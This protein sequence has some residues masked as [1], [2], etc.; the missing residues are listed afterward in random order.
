MA[1]SSLQSDIEA[2][3]VDGI[4]TIIADNVTTNGLSNRAYTM[5]D[6]IGDLP[7]VIV[8]SEGGKEELYNYTIS[9]SV[10]SEPTDEGDSNNF[11][12]NTK[13]SERVKAVRNVIMYNDLMDDLNSASS[14]T[15][16]LY[17]S[18]PSHS[19]VVENGRVYR[20]EQIIEIIAAPA[21]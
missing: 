13:H 8:A 9:V 4:R 20:S 1:F 5:Y 21:G 3:L 2:D 10:L 11:Y 19:D 6:D 17:I 15:E 12:R 16:V 7:A 14:N 18:W